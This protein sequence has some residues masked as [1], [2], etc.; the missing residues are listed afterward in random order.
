M[1]GGYATHDYRVKAINQR[2]LVSEFPL[3]RQVT[4]IA[5]LMT[6]TSSKSDSH[7]EW[8]AIA[9]GIRMPSFLF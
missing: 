2:R 3:H 8:S 4:A 5:G 1:Q 6:S 9:E 7:R